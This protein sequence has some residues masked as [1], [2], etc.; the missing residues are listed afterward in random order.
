MQ[1]G[2]TMLE[3][4]RPLIVRL[5]NWVGDV[6]LSTPVLL[7]LQEHGHELTLVGKGW[8][9]DLLA[10]FGW[11]VL[12]LGATHG[13]RVA[14][15]AQWRRD[16]AQERWG[17][18]KGINAIS[19]PYSAS[20]ALEMR[21]A[22][23]KAIG[24][25]GEGRALLLH[26]SWP[27]PRLGRS[28]HEL[29]VYWRLGQQLL[30]TNEAPPA[31]LQWRV[32]ALHQGRAQALMQQH[33]LA[34]GFVMLCPFAGGTFEGQ[35]KRWPHFEAYAQAAQQRS[36]RP[37]VL[38]PGPGEEQEAARQYPGTVILPGVDLGTCAALMQQASVMV[39]NDTGPG[40]LAAAVGAPLVSVLG[41]T[42]PAHWGAW[43][44]TVRVVRHWPRWPTV[45]EVWAA[46]QAPWAR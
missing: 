46:S 41:P 12:R 31:A 39:S 9:P 4:R 40:H 19:F 14:Q 2:A 20:S 33:G 7:R 38:C 44:P 24:Y 11:P 3:A 6:V 10:G 1:L 45:D 27:R 36:A 13:E 37:L 43:G 15:L 17:S 8:A 21:M 18:P 30:G 35:D 29:Q 22:G 42:E 23:L 34:P 16:V 32:S 28:G 5:R 25:D 26:R